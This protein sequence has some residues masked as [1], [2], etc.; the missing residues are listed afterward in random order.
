MLRSVCLMLQNSWWPRA[1]GGVPRQYICVSAVSNLDMNERLASLVEEGT[2]K[3]VVDSRW[4]MA[5]AVKVRF[6]FYFVSIPKPTIPRCI[7]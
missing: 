5:D 7:R 3:T 2:L 4:E 6:T 1:L